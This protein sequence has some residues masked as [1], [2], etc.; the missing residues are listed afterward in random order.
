MHML[1]DVQKKSPEILKSASLHL[2]M[3]KRE[4]KAMQKPQPQPQSRPQEA[5]TVSSG[6]QHMRS[7]C[8]E[9]REVIEQLGR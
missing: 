7:M 8:N 6:V 5:Q 9:L 2:S 3:E 4:T 1:A